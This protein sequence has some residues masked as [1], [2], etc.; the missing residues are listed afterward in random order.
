MLHTDPFALLSDLERQFTRTTAP[1]RT[2]WL[3]AA[4]VIASDH[5]IRVIMDAPGVSREDL[6]IEVRDG[7]LV[8]TVIASPST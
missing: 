4:D 6:D 1:A 5:E 3:P 2:G 8:I 7:A